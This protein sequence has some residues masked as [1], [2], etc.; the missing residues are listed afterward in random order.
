MGLLE[1]AHRRA[2]RFPPGFAGFTAT[3]HSSGS[4]GPAKLEVR[5]RR[6]FDL[7]DADV[8]TRE[9]VASILGHRW[10]S[11]FHTEGDGRYQHHEEADGDP[12][13][14]MVRLE[15]DPLSSAYRVSDD[16]EIAEVHRAPGDTPFTIVISGG[17]ESGQGRLPQHFSV[18]YWSTD[19]GRRLTKVDQFRD[20][21]VEVDGVWLPRKR[22]VTTVT[23]TGVST[24]ELAFTDH[25]LRDA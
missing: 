7:S 17:V 2:Y 10:A 18:Y 9:Q 13:G 25:R 19:G 3:V 5:G 21:Y 23:D 11:D 22:V 6:D 14:T 12:S 1:R 8:W 16:E 24:R 4:N 20:R 15:G